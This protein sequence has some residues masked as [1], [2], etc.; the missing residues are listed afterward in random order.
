MEAVHGAAVSEMLCLSFLNVGDGDAAYVE[1]R[2]G[3]RIFRML[4]DTGS[5]D[6][7][8]QPGSLRLSAADFLRE[9]NV[10]YL[11]AVVI[12]HLHTDHFGGLGEILRTVEVGTV[13]ARF[14]PKPLARYFC[15]P[16]QIKSVRG[17][18]ECLNLWSDFTEILRSRGT[19]LRELPRER[20]TLRLWDGLEATFYGAPAALAALE[21]RVYSGIPAGQTFS[22]P[23]LYLVSKLR[24]PCSLRLR[25][26]YAGR[27][28]EL[29]GDCYGTMWEQT[30]EA[31]DLLKV[32][33]HGDPKAL[34]PGLV[35]RLQPKWA[36]ISCAEDYIPKKDRPSQ[37]TLAL[38]EAA[39]V[40]VSFT[41][42]F[43]PP[44][45]R[46]VYH[47]SVDFCIFKDGTVLSPTQGK[48]E[49]I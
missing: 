34:T 26:R 20:E 43:S 47:K 23:E 29:P 36:V 8:P 25:L 32:P 28:I 15:P 4:V 45:G 38:L 44:G 39:G 41:D 7:N 22:I 6:V 14:F 12:T 19:A 37:R 30:A 18:Y 33:H 24:N 1:C 42:A 3:A 27:Q 49:K 46:A 48:K 21:T 2:F 17:L 40:P 9:R 31:C 13:Y 10:R 16:G 11:D 5:A 35:A